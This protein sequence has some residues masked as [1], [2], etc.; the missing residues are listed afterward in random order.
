MKLE[1]PPRTWWM[2]LGLGVAFYAFVLFLPVVISILLLL[3]MTALLTLLLYPLADRFEQYGMKRSLTVG[4]VLLLVALLFGFLIVEI[5]PLVANS[6]SAL[7]RNIETLSPMVETYLPDLFPAATE[8]GVSPIISFVANSLLQFASNIGG[9]VGQIGGL[10]FAFFVIIVLVLNLVSDPR[11]SRVL[12]QFFVPQQY[13]Q[14]LGFLTQRVS[15]GLSRWFVAQLSISMYYIVCYGTVNAVLDVPYGLS[16]AIIAGLLEFIPYLGG[17]VGLVLSMLA[18]ATVSS[19][20]VIWIFVSNLIIGSVCV[21]FVSPYFYSRAINVPV[22]AILLG[23]FIGG[24][25]G[26]FFAALLTVPVV[27]I[28]V[29]LARELRPIPLLDAETVDNAQV[30]P[31]AAT[32]TQLSTPS[33]EQQ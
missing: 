11:M 17:I 13:H 8:D 33:G 23:L 29:I 31:A 24:Q 20:T 18:A 22:G 5:I 4:I 9:L 16:I 3:T 32:A 28:I 12:M 25:I 26:G 2:L 7:A 1:I 27:T 10:F 15:E 21:Y 19:T 14:R 30:E 6:L